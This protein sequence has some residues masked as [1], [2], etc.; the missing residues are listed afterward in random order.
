MPNDDYYGNGRI[1][2][3][4]DPLFTLKSALDTNKKQI[5]KKVIEAGTK[6]YS[7]NLVDEFLKIIRL[8]ENANAFRKV[9]I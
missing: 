4:L 2:N 6:F 7:D 1:Q 8:K 9:L 5:F 3:R